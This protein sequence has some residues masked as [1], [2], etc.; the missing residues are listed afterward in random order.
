MRAYLPVLAPEVGAIIEAAENPAE[1][2]G[3]PAL[4]NGRIATAMGDAGVQASRKTD[5][6]IELGCKGP[7]LTTVRTAPSPEGG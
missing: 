3:G 5:Y 1:M 6:A 2:T 7:A 4:T